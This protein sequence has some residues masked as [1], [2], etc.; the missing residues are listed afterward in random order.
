MNN[1]SQ[2]KRISPLEEGAKNVLILFLGLAGFA[3]ASFYLY[4]E[5]ILLTDQINV[6]AVNYQ[7]WLQALK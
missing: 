6:P 2:V 5:V 7:E 4:T 1:L 3:F